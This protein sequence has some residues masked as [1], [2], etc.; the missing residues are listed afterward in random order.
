MDLNKTVIHTSGA[1]KTSVARVYMKKGS[2]KIVVNDRDAEEYFPKGFVLY[3]LYQ[4]IEITNNKGNFD[5]KINVYGGG[6]NSQ[7]EAIRLAISRALLKNS[8]DDAKILKTTSFLTRDSRKVERKHYGHKKAR[9][10]F[11]FSK[12]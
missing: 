2:G 3:K 5:I 12:R 1:R 9:R 4:P 11:Q 6:F 8:V 10:S 7:V